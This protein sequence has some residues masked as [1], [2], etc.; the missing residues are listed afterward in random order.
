MGRDPGDERGNG[1]DRW[2]D[3]CGRS[4]RRWKDREP[5]KD[6]GVGPLVFFGEERLLLVLPE[7]GRLIDHRSYRNERDGP[8]NHAGEETR[9]PQ[10]GEIGGEGRSLSFHSPRE[11]RN[12]EPVPGYSMRMR[13]TV[14]LSLPPR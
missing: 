3:G 11:T 4:F 6:D 7:F 14:I 1:R 10:I 12:P 5:G 9:L 13:R 2:P 8:A